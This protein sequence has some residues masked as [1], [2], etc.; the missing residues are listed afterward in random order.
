M[1]GCRVTS[2][3]HDLSFRFAFHQDPISAP[4]PS[5]R[6]LCCFL[7]FFGV[8]RIPFLLGSQ[9]A[10]LRL[11]PNQERS[12]LQLGLRLP[13]LKSC[14]LQLTSTCVVTMISCGG[15]SVSGDGLQGPKSNPLQ[16]KRTTGL[17][18]DMAAHK[19]VYD[20]VVDQQV[21]VGCIADANSHWVAFEA[22]TIDSSLEGPA[23]VDVRMNSFVVGAVRMVGWALP[24][25]VVVDKVVFDMVEARTVAASEDSK[26][27]VGMADRRSRDLMTPSV[28]W[29][30][31]VLGTVVRPAPALE[32]ALHHE[33]WGDACCNSQL[34]P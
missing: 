21:V 11:F 33:M 28:V 32:L 5:A 29:V 12:N 34:L 20:A 4:I 18:V 16:R 13:H 9:P 30:V 10:H 15:A 27:A 25:P 6:S 23:A 3:L 1:L 7:S 17:G 24:L 2:S 26:W 22:G 19:M 8:Y 31:V 14:R